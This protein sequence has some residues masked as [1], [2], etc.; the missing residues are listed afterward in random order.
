MPKS[1]IK[2]EPTVSETRETKVESDAGEE[3][4]KKPK[5]EPKNWKPTL[6]KIQK[7]R[8]VSQGTL[9]NDLGMLK[10]Q[11]KKKIQRV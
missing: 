4:I 6:E 10:S 5:W 9:S 3:E 11:K 7:M 8:K 1:E 2:S